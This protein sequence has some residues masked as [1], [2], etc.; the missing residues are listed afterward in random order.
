MGFISHRL[1]E[2]TIY[3]RT[4]FD[5]PDLVVTRCVYVEKWWPRKMVVRGNRDNR[6]NHD[7]DAV[8]VVFNDDDDV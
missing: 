6:V 4:D 1:M 3:E 5:S 7:F 2:C 8:S